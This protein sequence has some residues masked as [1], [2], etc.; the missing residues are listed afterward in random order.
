MTW[1]FDQRFIGYPPIEPF[2]T[3][4]ALAVSTGLVQSLGQWPPIPSGVIVEA[5]D[6]VWGPGE[7]IFAKANGTIPLRAVCQLL[8]VWNATNR[9][10]DWNA[11][12]CANTANLGSMLAVAM[13]EQDAT[14]ALT[15]GQFG[16]FMI[17]GITP[18]ACGAN[19]AIGAALGVTAAGQGGA[20]A[21]GKNIL[22]ARVITASTQTVVV[23]SRSD[24]G[25]VTGGFIV[26]V[27]NTDGF[28]CG[29]VLTGTG[30]GASTIVK[31]IDRINNTLTVSVANTAA[32]SGNITITYATA[33]IFY[34]TVSMYRPF[35]QGQIT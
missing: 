12:V 20:F 27:A 3:T 35:S 30:M 13:S 25:G 21:A 19:L 29:G 7:F 5:E 14:N 18:M 34:N 22:P 17:S 2:L 15:T 8:P 10:F 26:P 4:A 11:T 28:F 33:A 9:N 6:P 32:P 24:P 31:A 16:Y 23:A 1:K